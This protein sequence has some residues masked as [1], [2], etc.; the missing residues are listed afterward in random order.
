MPAEAVGV[1]DV[2][3]GLKFIDKDLQDRIR[4]AIDPLMRNV[5]AKARSFVPGNAE[6]LSGW[7]KE[8][9]PNINYRPFPK[10]D[11][12]TVKA[13]IGYN[14]GDNRTFKNGFKVSNYVYNVSAPGRI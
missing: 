11:A 2:L 4:T 10:Y 13:G 7:T 12:G 3:A 14:S 9:N 6:V 5:A 8:P 1:K